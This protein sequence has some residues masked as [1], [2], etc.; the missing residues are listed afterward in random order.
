MTPAYSTRAESV[1]VRSFDSMTVFSGAG[2][3]T[4]G[5]AATAALRRQGSSHQVLRSATFTSTHLTTFRFARQSIACAP[6]SR[7]DV[8]RTLTTGSL[9][10]SATAIRVV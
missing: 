2:A 10:S 9:V 1:F 7:L 5:V 6:L 3:A 8:P 4:L